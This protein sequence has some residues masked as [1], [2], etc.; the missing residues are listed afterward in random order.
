MKTTTPATPDTATVASVK[1][2]NSKELVVT[3]NIEVDGTDAVDKAKYAVEGETISS[4]AVSE[5]GKTVTLTTTD[6]IKWI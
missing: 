3:F 2:G 4:V 5:D 1:A 6:V